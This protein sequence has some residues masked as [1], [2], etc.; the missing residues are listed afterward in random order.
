MSRVSRRRRL[1]GVTVTRVA[2]RHALA[3]E[4]IGALPWERMGAVIV[5]RG[6]DRFN[7]VALV[8]CPALDLDVAQVRR[9]LHRFEAEAV[10]LEQVL[11]DRDPL[12]GV[13]DLREELEERGDRL[14]EGFRVAELHRSC[15][16]R[17]R[18]VAVD[19]DPERERWDDDPRPH[20][21]GDVEIVVLERLGRGAEAGQREGRQEANVF[22]GHGSSSDQHCDLVERV[23]VRDAQRAQVARLYAVAS[24]R[25]SIQSTRA[26]EAVS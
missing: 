17:D 15:R 4:E 11:R 24:P 19:L 3:R 23:P 25:A 20:G 22:D 9:P 7:L 12:L 21:V 8:A 2:E 10:L 14:D 13:V 1:P 18:E 5:E 26:M 6:R 16:P